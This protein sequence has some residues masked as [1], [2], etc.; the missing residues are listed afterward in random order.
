[1][2][3]IV[4]GF[5]KDKHAIGKNIVKRYERQKNRGSNGFGFVC[6]N[7]K[8]VSGSMRFESEGEVCA[9]LKASGSSHIMFH[10][11]LP[12]STPN[13]EEANHPITVDNPSLENIFYVV[14]NGVLQNERELRTKH[15][16]AGFEYS[17]IVEEMNIVRT[18]KGDKIKG[19]I[20]RF[21]DSEALAIELALFFSGKKETIDTRGTVAFV[22]WESD[23]EGNLLKVHYGRNT[24]NPLVMEDSGDIMFIKSEGNSE[25]D[26]VIPENEIFT[27]DQA[28]GV[29]T[30][31]AVDV[32]SCY[33]KTHASK[34]DTSFRD[35][36][37]AI[38]DASG[39]DIPDVPS[40]DARITRAVGFHLN[41]E[42]FDPNYEEDMQS[43]KPTKS[44]LQPDHPMVQTRMVHKGTIFPDDIASE[45][46]AAGVPDWYDWDKE[47]EAYKLNP[48][49]LYDLW[50]EL[51]NLEEEVKTLRQTL[52]DNTNSRRVLSDEAIIIAQ[53]ELREALLIFNDKKAESERLVAYHDMVKQHGSSN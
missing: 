44:F 4:Y 16:T 19:K 5:R 41:E 8:R 30:V 20:E 1:M 38:A 36:M 35:H 28:T 22:C 39:R 50:E 31:R 17:T 21:N 15:E 53:E 43:G 12:T 9:A 14:H 46:D 48:S 18:K 26:T 45:I 37:L 6:V 34:P 47:Y 11:R 49:Y 13:C 42:E 27:I 10:H 25:H 23:R 24:G 40:R 33:I 32:G 7:G 29:T 52:N 3:G 2:C 51:Y